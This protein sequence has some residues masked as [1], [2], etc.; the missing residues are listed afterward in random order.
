MLCRVKY[1][2]SSCRARRAAR[3]VK[4]R[5][6]RAGAS[7]SVAYIGRR[8]ALIEKVRQRM[9]IVYG[10]H[11]AIGNGRRKSVYGPARARM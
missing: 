8:R 7:D 3:G 2:A 9:Y 6:L 4:R 10:G 1:E 11:V 5:A